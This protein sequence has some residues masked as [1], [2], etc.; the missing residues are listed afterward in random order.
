LKIAHW[1]DALNR[2]SWGETALELTLRLAIVG[3]VLSTYLYLRKLSRLPLTITRQSALL[4][5]R[6]V[7][8]AL[9]AAIALYAFAGEEIT[10][11]F[12]QVPLLSVWSVSALALGTVI[13]TLIFRR[14]SLL[15]A[16]DELR[17]DPHDANGLG[18]W[19]KATIASMVLAMSIGSYGFM[20][21]MMGYARTV[22][23][24]FFFVSV[25]MLILW[26]PHLDGGTI[27]PPNPFSNQ[28]DAK[29]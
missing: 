28:T 26:R 23:W 12:D 21:R 16:N 24:P 5:A 27:S 2:A 4:T 22:E 17:R 8:G 3:S 1:N 6:A 29:S 18:R 11:H 19:R 13:T 10:E 9:L 15:R 14:R 25:A 20:L 7:Q